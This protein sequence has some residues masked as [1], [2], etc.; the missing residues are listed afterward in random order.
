M[1]TIL[2]FFVRNWRFSMVLTGMLALAGAF[3]LLSLRR[4][5]FPPVSFA[6]AVVTA[7]Y[8]GASA[9]EVEEQVTNV[10]EDELRGIEGIKDVR[11]TSQPELAS[12]VVRVD[13]DRPDAD[14]IINDIQ[15]AVQR[16]S[17]RLPEE[18]LE[19]PQVLELN[20]KEIPVI[21]VALTGDNTG[22]AR[23]AFAK[24]MQKRLEDITGVASIQ[25]SGYAPPEIQ[26]LLDQSRMRER[27]VSTGEVT[28]AIASTSRNVPAGYL[29]SD[30]SIR[31]VRVLNQGRTAEDIGNVV[32][33]SNFS[34]QAVRVKDVATVIEGSKQATLLARF[35]GEPATLFT[36]TKKAD[37][38]AYRTVE[39]I[40]NVINEFRTKL[41]AGMELHVYNDEGM[42]IA[43]RLEIVSNNALAGMVIVLLVLFF[44]LPGKIGILSAFSLPVCVFGT[45][46]F[47]V[48]GGAT[49]NIITML[50]LI[51]CL[52]NLVDNSVVVSEQYARLRERGM[53]AQEAAIE[54]ARQFW[55]PFTASTITIVASFLPMLV[56]KG[57]MGQFI[58]WIPIVVSAALVVSLIEALT[59]L[60]ARLQFVKPKLV[61]APSDG[62]SSGWF[63]KIERGFM[64]IVDACLRWRLLTTLGLTSL[65]AS[66]I[67]VTVM[68]NRFELFPAEG[69]EYYIARFDRP[70]GTSI[71]STDRSGASLVPQI[72]AAV[73]KKNLTGVVTRA[74]AQRFDAGDPLSKDG[75]NV[76]I[77]VIAIDPKV[78]PDLPVKGTLDALRKIPKSSEFDILSWETLNNGPPV[79]RPLTVTLRAAEYAQ[80]RGMADA[81]KAELATVKGAFD[82]RDDEVSTGPEFTF[83]P[84]NLAIRSLGLDV[85]SV[86]G[87]LRNALQG[88][89]PAKF[90]SDDEE[91]EVLVRN[92]DAARSSVASLSRELVANRMGDLIPLRNVGQISET[93]G[94]TFRKHYNF[95]RSITV[96]G[97]VDP[98]IITST[99]L[100]AE[101]ERIIKSLLP[102]FPTVVYDFG[103]EEEETNESMRSLA[104][105]LALAIVGIFATLVFTFRSFTKPLLILSSIPLGLIGVCYAFAL[106]QRPL[107]FLAFIGIVGL[108]GVVINSAIILVDYVEQLRIEL[109][110]TKTLREILVLASGQR[111]RAVLA[112]GLTTVVGLVPTAFGLGGY[113]AILVPMTLALSW[114]MIVGTVLSLIWIPTGYLV[115]ES[116]KTSIGRII[117]FQQ[118]A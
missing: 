1:N 47:M 113:D 54:A 6:V 26:V 9:E 56:T 75:E 22:R 27:H 53:A 36:A 107:S 21:E 66:G 40:R 38:D 99:A 13:I 12:L 51:I 108:S 62:T 96:T 87:S 112:T 91:V 90:T 28:A 94:P 58:K 11:S 102:K 86:G 15:R 42:R 35:D 89:A 80:L 61:S 101:A 79:G 60:P 52:G 106:D 31:M 3:G 4:E 17:A 43:N 82:I 81:L 16:S 48:Y 23:E 115:L 97:D 5:A 93:Q 55:V 19:D 8:P 67:A 116:M 72:E 85:E 39:D 73:G 83:A 33:R 88:I 98:T 111:L 70:L 103:G 109:G 78:V 71:D 65:V 63:G 14:E 30:E 37:A 46:A 7:V 69:V 105:A 41:P 74:G 95:R 114:G 20:A 76:G 84:D 100:N 2:A 68:F 10:I 77:A 32:V 34:R 25:L 49:F 118:R 24:I 92:S 18:L 64:R 57:V 104:F 45:V 44:F 110:A 117:G 29:R 59:L 50:A